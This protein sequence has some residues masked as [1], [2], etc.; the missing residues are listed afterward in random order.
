MRRLQIWDRDMRITKLVRSNDCVVARI[1][2]S[3]L[4]VSACV[5]KVCL[6]GK[7]WSCKL[8]RTCCVDLRD[9]GRGSG[10]GKGGTHCF[11]GLRLCRDPTL[12]FSFLVDSSLHSKPQTR[13][14][15]DSREASWSRA[16]M[17]LPDIKRPAPSWRLHWVLEDI[18]F[19]WCFDRVISLLWSRLC[20]SVAHLAVSD[21]YRGTLE[22]PLNSSISLKRSRQA[23]QVAV[24][25]SPT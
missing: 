16:C 17:K 1:R 15:A 4:F 12:M 14:V 6:W 20:C 8:Y 9:T 5:L 23:T 13:E 7:T 10:T 2:K 25:R 22:M 21:T 11:K 3:P 19:V 18:Y 24:K